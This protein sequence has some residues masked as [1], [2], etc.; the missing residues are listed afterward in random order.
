[1]HFSTNK[2]REDAR[3]VSFTADI[4]N[5]TFTMVGES[6]V[7]TPFLSLVWQSITVTT[8]G[9]AI[10]ETRTN[11]EDALMRDVTGSMAG[12]RIAD[13][14][15]AAKDLVDIIVQN[16][17]SE[18]STRVAIVP[19]SHAVNAGTT[20]GPHVAYNPTKELTFAFRDGKQRKWNRTDEYCVS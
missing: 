3:V 19:F 4:Q 17:Q 1:A 10:M 6:S 5:A 7:P 8:R 11:L 15:D 13:L 9:Q 14:K 16:D 12:Q 18:Y 2:Q 20:L